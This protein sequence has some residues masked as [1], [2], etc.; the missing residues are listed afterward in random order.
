MYPQ[1][2][3][4]IPL[5]IEVGATD[6][7]HCADSG[8][9]G[10]YSQLLILKEYMSRLANDLGFEEEDIYPAD[11]FDL[12]GGT[13]FGGWVFVPFHPVKLSN[14]Y[15]LVAVILGHLRMNVEEAI[16]GLITVATTIFPEGY[17]DVPDPEV[18]S[19]NLKSAMEKMLRT[20]EITVNA[21]M[22]ERDSPQKRCK[23]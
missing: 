2:R 9:P 22:R 3:Y 21:K 5:N 18:N 17:Q 19:K 20:K 1:L 6:L 12:I 14:G 11:H 10:T 7:V 16:D 8:G 4:V 13:G 23:V 15:S